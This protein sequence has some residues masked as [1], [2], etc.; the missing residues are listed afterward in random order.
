ML[1]HHHQH[2]CAPM[3]GCALDLDKE[4][5][6]AAAALHELNL[7]STIGIDVVSQRRSSHVSAKNTVSFLFGSVSGQANS[8]GGPCVI[9]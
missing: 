3:R 6:R 8:S 1:Q 7:P 2:L 4:K 5:F 9:H